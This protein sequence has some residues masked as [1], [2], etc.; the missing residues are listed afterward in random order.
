[1]EKK[2]N[3][4]SLKNCLFVN[5]FERYLDL[6]FRSLET[7]ALWLDLDGVLKIQDWIWIE[8]HD[9]PLISGSN[10]LKMPEVAGVTF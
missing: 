9:N 6:D 7:I 8:K 2:C 1:M 3:Y 10:P 5:F 4:L